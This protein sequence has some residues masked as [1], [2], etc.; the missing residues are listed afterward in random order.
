MSEIWYAVRTAPGACRPD[1]RDD[2]FMKIERDLMDHGFDFYLPME[3]RDIV[4]HRTKKMVQ[5]RFPLIPGYAF[6]CSVTNFWMLSECKTVSGILGIEGEPMALPQ[7]EID[8][9]RKAETSI[10]EDLAIDRRK[11][12]R[13]KQVMT[14][15]RLAGSYPSG[16]QV[17][18]NTGFLAAE[19]GRVIATTGRKTVKL[20]LDRLANLGVIELPVDELALVA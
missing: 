4:H 16:A 5:K 19:P 11:R 8:E 2:R 10:F 18:V 7:S 15:K 9:I 13:E 6:V 3:V 1:R 20:T 17:V 12:A 14:R